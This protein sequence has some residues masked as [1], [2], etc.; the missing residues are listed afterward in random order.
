MKKHLILIILLLSVSIAGCD[1]YKPLTVG[2]PKTLESK[3]VDKTE[4]EISF[5]IPIQ[6]PNFYS[7]NVTDIQAKAYVNNKVA[8]KI[9]NHDKL[10]IP[11]KSAKD[12]HITFVV[13]ITDIFPSVSSILKTLSEGMVDVSIEGEIKARSLFVNKSVKF[14]KSKKIRPEDLR[15][16]K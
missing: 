4:F 2:N 10:K 9:V 8:G 12:H 13:D 15:K 1:V 3:P 6:N 5:D 11:A 16:K 7:I 14:N